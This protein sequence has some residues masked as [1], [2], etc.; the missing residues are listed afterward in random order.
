MITGQITEEEYI[1]AHTL[2]RRKTQSILKRITILVF[3]IGI[4]LFFALSAKLGLVLMCTAL[5]GLL[6]ELIQN[7][8]I[9]PLK[10]RRL[11]AQIRGR[12][13]V[14]YSWDGEKLF[15]SS[16]HGHAARSWSDFLKAKEN[17]ELILLYINDV[18]YE[19]IAKRWF[20]NASDLNAFRAHLK[21][22]N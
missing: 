4:I 12:V 17:D 16:E 13:D 11:C 5:G 18:R 19:I 7:R 9:L 20:G 15:L 2:H 1:A 6:G 8:L 10:L 14:S 3:I 21:L 22:V